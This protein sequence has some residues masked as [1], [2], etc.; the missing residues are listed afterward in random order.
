MNLG[1]VPQGT[2]VEYRSKLTGLRNVKHFN[3]MAADGKI[4][5]T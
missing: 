5:V 1:P 3:A 4:L 2:L